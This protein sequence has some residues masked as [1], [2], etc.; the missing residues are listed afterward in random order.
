M[1][2]FD[3]GDIWCTEVEETSSAMEIKQDD[4]TWLV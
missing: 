1:G 3:H 4:I 2:K